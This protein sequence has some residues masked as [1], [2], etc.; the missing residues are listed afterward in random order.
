MLLSA[1]LSCPRMESLAG[2]QL[3]ID[4][5]R[6]INKPPLTYRMAESVTSFP[7]PI[8]AKQ[9]KLKKERV[10]VKWIQ[11]KSHVKYLAK[12]S[13]QRVKGIRITQEASNKKGR[14]KSPGRKG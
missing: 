6:K 5:T 7:P 12:C 3:S 13:R 4:F 9:F 14:E 11:N 2:S 1:W 8:K 10:V